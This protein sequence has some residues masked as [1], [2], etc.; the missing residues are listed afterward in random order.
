MR[1]EWREERGR[2]QGRDGEGLLAIVMVCHERMFITHTGF[3]IH[4]CFALLSSHSIFSRFKS[5]GKTKVLGT[6][7]HS[8][9]ERRGRHCS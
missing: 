3:K 6:K 1:D 5:S 8:C 7:S 4:F 2:G 9:E